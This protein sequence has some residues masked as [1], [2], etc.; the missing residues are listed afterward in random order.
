MAEFISKKIL[1]AGFIIESAGFE[2]TGMPYQEFTID[3][4]NDNYKMD[5]QR[6]PSKNVKQFDLSTFD[7]IY[8]L[9]YK[10]WK[11]LKEVE[12]IK[13][14]IYC[15]PIDDPFETNKSVYSDTFN[16]IKTVIE[17]I[18]KQENWIL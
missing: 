16:Q 18:G 4:I 10:I 5:A 8:V 6:L 2:S 17:S 14:K 13:N 7:K 15:Y 11:K 3:I 12:S 9:D 1:P